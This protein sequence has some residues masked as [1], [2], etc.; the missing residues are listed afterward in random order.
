LVYHDFPETSEA[1]QSLELQC[2]YVRQHYNPV[3]MDE[4]VDGLKSGHLA[5]RSVAITIDDGYRDFLEVAGPVFRAHNLPVTLYL[6]SDLLDGKWMW[7]DRIVYSIKATAKTRISFLANGIRY[8]F[9]TR[10]VDP[11][12]EIVERIK[13]FPDTQRRAFVDKLQEEAQVNLPASNL[14]LSW[15]EARQ[16]M[17]GGVLFGAHTKSHPILSRVE[18]TRD[19]EFEVSVS[20]K[21]VEEETG[22]AVRHFCYPNGMEDDIDSHVA[23]VVRNAGLSSAVTSLGGFNTSDADLFALRRTG[24]DVPMSQAY[25]CELLAG[26]HDPPDTR[27]PVRL[28]E[29]QKRSAAGN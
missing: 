11:M 7:W 26:L 14:A 5:P 22:A 20:C 6:I 3:T 18:S 21:R 12:A 17:A 4:M 19:L 28:K 29:R 23:D 10:S 16:L 24:V 1:R 13:Q 27:E 25:F 8:D 2:A 9:D 15:N